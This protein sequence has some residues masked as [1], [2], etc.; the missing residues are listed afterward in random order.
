MIQFDSYAQHRRKISDS[1]HVVCHWRFRGIEQL[2]ASKDR[3]ANSL[4][5]RGR[6]Y[7]NE[8]SF[9]QSISQGLLI[10]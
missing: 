7:F 2:L 5:S 1:L 3:A 8:I 4:G 9:P 6:V 10:G